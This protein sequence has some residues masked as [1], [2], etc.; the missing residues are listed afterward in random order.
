MADESAGYMEYP[1]LCPAVKGK[2]KLS[3]PDCP[4]GMLTGTLC[5]LKDLPVLKLERLDSNVP[6]ESVT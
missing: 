3:D 1:K 6:V 2:V 5:K 4:S